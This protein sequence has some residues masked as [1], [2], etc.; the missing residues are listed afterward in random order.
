MSSNLL[1]WA[2]YRR[3]QC[4]KHRPLKISSFTWMNEILVHN[5]IPVKINLRK[6]WQ[7][8][9]LKIVLTGMDKV[10]A[11]YLDS[12][13]S[14]SCFKL[15]PLESTD[16]PLAQLSLTW[17]QLVFWMQNK[18]Y[19]KLSS[20]LLKFQLC[21]PFLFL[22][23]FHWHKYDHHMSCSIVIHTNIYI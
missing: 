1:W 3:Q 2:Q 13:L 6:T 7:K 8:V 14:M 12:W 4:S 16:C 15:T 18:L 20:N 10:F 21:M 23:Y 5:C 9:F 22:F 11:L 17:N 19:N